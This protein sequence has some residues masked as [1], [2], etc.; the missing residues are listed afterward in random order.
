MPIP[1]IVHALPTLCATLLFAALLWSRQESRTAIRVTAER[2][3]T[4]EVLLRRLE[5]ANAE[6]LVAG[7]TL[8]DVTLITSG[9][10]R[11][12]LRSLAAAGYR[13]LYFYRK[14]CPGCQILEEAWP[15]ERAVA[16]SPR[17]AFIAYS[18]VE[19]TPSDSGP[20]RYAWRHSNGEARKYLHGIPSALVIQPDGHI[21]A[22]A[23]ASLEQTAKL[24]DLAGVL[25]TDQVDSALQRTIN[26][27][28]LL[29]AG[30]SRP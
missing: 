4:L 30:A 25:T 5:R 17:T 18:S 29:Q 24:L 19:D 7:D 28:Q 2:A 12:N 22:A 20:S 26:A 11:V 1:R 16:G 23:H 10:T 9:G 6:A 3:D 14:D 8:P 27:S 21:V 15:Y 13:I